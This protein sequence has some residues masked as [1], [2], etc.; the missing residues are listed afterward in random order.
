[1][2]QQIQ[3]IGADLYISVFNQ[4]LSK[5]GKVGT[6]LLIIPHMLYLQNWNLPVHKTIYKSQDYHYFQNIGLQDRY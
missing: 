5:Y 3:S 2:S 1:M 4:F 6:L